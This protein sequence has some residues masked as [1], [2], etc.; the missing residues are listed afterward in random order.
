M[1]KL[2]HKITSRNLIDFPMVFRGL[3]II[4]VKSEN[5]LLQNPEMRRLSVRGKLGIVSVASFAFVGQTV[6]DAGYA[7]T[8][9]RK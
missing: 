1:P 4:Y 2:F 9:I 6:G 5:Q 8:P 3:K 7:H